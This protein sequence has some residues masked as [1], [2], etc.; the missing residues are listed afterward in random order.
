MVW[1]SPGGFKRL[2]NHK[3]EK[4]LHLKTHSLYLFAVGIDLTPVYSVEV[5]V[6]DVSCTGRVLQQKLER[7]ELVVI[8]GTMITVDESLDGRMREDI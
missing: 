8:V 6:R 3:V 1:M 4:F 2:I 7:R 5:C